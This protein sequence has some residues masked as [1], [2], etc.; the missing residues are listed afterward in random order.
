MPSTVPRLAGRPRETLPGP[1][2]EAG[3]HGGG[4]G[5]SKV[6]HKHRVWSAK[7]FCPMISYPGVG[8]QHPESLGRARER[9]DAAVPDRL[10]HAA[11]ASG[12]S[13]I[14]I[15]LPPVCSGAGALRPLWRQYAPPQALQSPECGA[16]QRPGRGGPAKPAKPPQLPAELILGPRPRQHSHRL[17][18]CPRCGLDSACARRPA[19]WLLCAAG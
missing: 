16:R 9:L 3:G 17:R 5:R 19:W 15:H 18:L 12:T 14:G 2:R 10:L 7:A 4:T 13:Q 11:A 8:V 6:L 1:E